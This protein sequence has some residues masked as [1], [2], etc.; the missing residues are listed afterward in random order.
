MKIK[1]LSILGIIL[2]AINVQAQEV[3][4]SPSEL[5]H[6][7]THSHYLPHVHSYQF[8]PQNARDGE[9]VEYCM[10]H[11]R[12]NELET[13]PEWA[14]ILDTTRILKAQARAEEVHHTA[15]GTIYYIPVVFH[16]LH[17]G[18]I[19]NISNDQIHDA[20]EILNLDFSLQNTD[21]ANVVQAFNASNPNAQSIP[22]NAEIQFRLATKAPNGDCFSGITRTQSTLSY[23]TSTNQGQDQVNAV[24]NGNNVYQGSWP[25]DEYL[26]VFICG[27]VGGAAGYTYT[28][29]FGF[30]GMNNGIWLL[31]NYI[32]SIGTGSAFTSRALTHEV[33]HWLDLQHQQLFSFQIFLLNT[34][35]Q[36]LE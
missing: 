11:K 19:E 28:P 9:S 15:K 27:D 20:I 22:A 10:T 5:P 16:I 33:G 1:T 25:G 6:P 7:H 3:N 4:K 21:A 36:K 8:D 30:T 12:M 14:A 32:G 31:H 29:Q 26:N 13:S 34:Q 17:N 35:Y 24:A 18:G 2:L 23:V